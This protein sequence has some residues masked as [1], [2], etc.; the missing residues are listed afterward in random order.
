MRAGRPGA[1]GVEVA[2]VGAGVTGAGVTAAGV[3]AVSA[4]WSVAARRGRDVPSWGR[5]LPRSRRR[6]LGG[7][8]SGTTSR[9]ASVTAI[10]S[11]R[12]PSS[13]ARSLTSPTACRSAAAGLGRAAFP[14]MG[15]TR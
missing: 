9:A 13:P 11:A 3:L 4:A 12:A 15:A 7:G 6:P 5:S 2:R 10:P 1:V 14:A 8:A